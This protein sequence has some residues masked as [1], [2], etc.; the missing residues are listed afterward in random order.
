MTANVAIPIN[1]KTT[2]AKT[3]P[4][5]KLKKRFAFGWPTSML[6]IISTKLQRNL[7]VLYRR[8]DMQTMQFIQIFYLVLFSFISIYTGVKQC[9]CQDLTGKSI[10]IDAWIIA[11]IPQFSLSIV[12]S[13]MHLRHSYCDVSLHPSKELSFNRCFRLI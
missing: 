2:A 3:Q 13:C 12:N 4:R 1:Q 5:W 10:G 7:Q 6:Q 9:S 11:I 8:L